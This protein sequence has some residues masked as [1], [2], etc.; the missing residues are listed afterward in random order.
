MAPQR[1][2][3]CLICYSKSHPLV[4]TPCNHNEIC[5]ICYVRVRS[6]D[7]SLECPICKT[8]NEQVVVGEERIPL[9]FE[10]YHI[11]GDQLG[12]N[13]HYHEGSGMFFPKQ[14]FEGTIAALF[15]Y[16]CHICKENDEENSS[17]TTYK[18]L[19]TH[20]RVEHRL[21]MCDLCVDN[22]RDFVSR[23]PRYSPAGLEKHKRHPTHGHA[24]C[25]FCKPMLYDATALYHH[26]RVEH[27]ECHIC[28]A[29]FRNYEELH[30]HF[31]NYHFACR[32]PSCI[33]AR[34]VAFGSELD[35]IQHQRQVH[36]VTAQPSISLNFRSTRRETTTEHDGEDEGGGGDSGLD[37]NGFTPPSVIRP[38]ESDGSTV[39]GLHPDHVRRTEELRQQAALL[40]EQESDD[41][42]VSDEVFPS[43]GD[44]SS[45]NAPGDRLQ[46]GWSDSLAAR[47]NTAVGN[48]SEEAFPSL[49]ASAAPKRRPVANTK[50]QQPVLPR[51]TGGNWAQQQ[52]PPPGLQRNGNSNWKSTT[53]PASQYNCIP[54][55]TRTTPSPPTLESTE[56]FP[57]LARSGSGGGGGWGKP[58]ANAATT[59]RKAAAPDMSQNNFP[60]LG[61]GTKKAAPRYAAAE[62]LAKKLQS[63]TSAV[64]Q[65]N[66][67]QAPPPIRKQPAPAPKK[68]WKPPDTQSTAQ[69][70]TL[71]QP[72]SSAARATA[73]PPTGSLDNI[74]AELGSSDYKAL[75]NLTKEYGTGRL[76]PEDYVDRAYALLDGND[77]FFRFVPAL[78]A[79][80]PS[81]HPAMAQNYIRELRV[82]RNNPAAAAKGADTAVA[83]KKKQ[84][85][86]QAKELRALAFGGA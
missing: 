76:A 61:P 25:K 26:L 12:D 57:S 33:A 46:I 22:K 64:H 15:Q 81:V 18:A 48:V 3:A 28:K 68:A 65:N 55:P 31:E 9:P 40:R 72:P 70:P 5:A 49:P 62:S 10:E 74:K 4:S 23:L 8:E 20:L 39:Q 35:L 34:F 80:C 52:P 73:P 27:Y 44:T 85:G 21:T 41:V 38:R 67:L 56:N 36:G 6:L 2:T 83:K 42:Y 82:Q 86:K 17:F 75:K 66:F 58:K 84:K 50:Q 47:S 59:A 63:S 69:F 1:Q 37:P 53:R 16:N 19:Q 51:R 79:S 54:V 32:D 11:W 30:R 14:Y 78:V 45:N 7:E 77:S 29:F 60:A 24:K 13:Y 71:S 43:L